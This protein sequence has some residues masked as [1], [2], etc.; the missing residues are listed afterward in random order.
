MKKI[1]ATA[2]GLLIIASVIGVTAASAGP[3]DTTTVDTSDSGSQIELAV[4]D[5]LRV[6]LESNPT[7]G[8]MWVLAE[9]SD[10]SVLQGEGHEYVMDEAGEP[11]QPGT[12]G[13]E[14][15]TFTAVA[16]GETTISMEYSRPWEGGEK[17]VRT[18]D[19]TVV[20]K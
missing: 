17:A 5:T 11:P 16:T 15:W 1:I 13:K 9:N 6:E 18:F 10:G 4:G 8:F 19:L 14:F 3:G 2:L 12:G 20:V 7:T